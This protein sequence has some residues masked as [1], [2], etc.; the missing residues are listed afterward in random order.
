MVDS[1]KGFGE[2]DKNTNR[3][4]LIRKRNGKRINK[5]DQSH[6]SR[7]TGSKTE[8]LVIKKMKLD[9]KEIFTETLGIQIANRE[10]TRRRITVHNFE[11][12]GIKI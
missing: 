2:I 12:V 10:F 8:L 4:L 1:I 11:A 3:R 5:L 6:I 7:V 9:D